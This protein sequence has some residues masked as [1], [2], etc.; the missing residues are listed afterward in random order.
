MILPIF[1][2]GSPVLRKKSFFIDSGDNVSEIISNMKLTLKNAGGIGLA[3]PQV[4]FLKNVFIIDT[5]PLKDEGMESVEKVYINPEIRDINDELIDFNEA[6]LSL[7]GIYEDVSRPEKIHV[8]YTD[9]NFN[10]QEETLDG[11]I[12]RI[13]QHEYDHLLG[14]LFIDK[15]N[16][17][18]RKM[19]GRRL[20]E[21]AR[22]G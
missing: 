6:C 14:I 8:R 2:Y 15:I 18:R 9:E 13:Y 12:A 5:S 22:S 16:P 1:K 7:P 17:L 20:K 4:G 3:G 21:L 10:I 19:L 11:L